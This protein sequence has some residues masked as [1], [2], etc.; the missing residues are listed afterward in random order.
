M[1]WLGLLQKRLI[2]R[3]DSIPLSSAEVWVHASISV[4]MIINVC[5]TLRNTLDK[6][7]SI[8]PL[9]MFP[10]CG[11]NAEFSAEGRT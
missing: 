1:Q 2:V 6:R 10:R 9:Q 3:M 7:C 8:R 4:V 5:R 11:E